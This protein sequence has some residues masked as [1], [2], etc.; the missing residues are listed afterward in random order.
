MVLNWT[1]VDI[2]TIQSPVLPCPPESTLG[3]NELEQLFKFWKILFPEICGVRSFLDMVRAHPSRSSLVEDFYQRALS[4][5]VNPLDLYKHEVLGPRY[6]ESHVCFTILEN[7]SSR[8]GGSSFQLTVR[9]LY[10]I[11]ASRSIDFFDGTYEICSAYYEMSHNIT[12]TMY[13]R[14]YRAFL[15]RILAN[16]TDPIIH[17]FSS[18]ITLSPNGPGT[19]VRDEKIPAILFT[20]QIATT[21]EHKDH[22]PLPGTKWKERYI[23]SH[24]VC[25]VFAKGHWVVFKNQW[26]LKYLDHVVARPHIEQTSKC[27]MEYDSILL[28]ADSHMR[29]IFYYMTSFLTGPSTD[30][31]YKSHLNLRYEHLAFAWYPKLD[32]YVQF[33]SELRDSLASGRFLGRLLKKKGK[34]GN[35]IMMNAGHH[36]IDWGAMRVFVRIEKVLTI[37]RDIFILARKNNVR[38][39]WLS[40]PPFPWKLTI[41]GY[42]RNNF[43]LAGMNRWMITQ[44]K[45]I[46]FEVIDYFDLIF[47]LNDY[48]VCNGHYM[49]VIPSTGEILGSPGQAIAD[50]IL[51]RICP[52]LFPQFMA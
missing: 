8:K 21:G 29:H 50:L 28:A 46:G 1:R 10:T 39:I 2:D 33:L 23:A 18:P 48:D 4:R 42:G 47:S 11:H 30:W 24:E 41:K 5:P 26:R 9:G 35:L 43:I 36:D 40:H 22:L 3:V 20:S 51:Y 7:I 34:H 13:F 49:C 37:L 52:S 45:R 19:L 15:Q 31:D 14:D 6:N 27:L 16:N 25:Q 44:L 38:L 32:D 12:L 17:L